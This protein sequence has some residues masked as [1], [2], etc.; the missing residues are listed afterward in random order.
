MLCYIEV[1]VTASCFWLH[2]M[3]L[4]EEAFIQQSVYVYLHTKNNHK[5]ICMLLKIHLSGQSSTQ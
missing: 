3:L 4:R 5:H 2:F 1:K